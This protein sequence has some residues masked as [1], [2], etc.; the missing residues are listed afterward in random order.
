MARVLITGST[1]GLGR[2]AARTLLDGGH[3]VILHARNPTRAASVDE[4]AGQPDGVVVGDL[5]SMEQTRR[6]AD[7]VNAI[8][9]TDAVIHNAGI[10]LD[11][12]RAETPEGHARTLAVNLLAPYALTAWI[13]RPPRL[14][15][16]SSGMHRSGDSSLNDID[17]TARRW[18][19][20]QA[21]CDS[22]LFLTALAFTVGRHWPDVCSH[23][24]DPGWVPT[25]MGGP[26]APD[27]L[28]LG[29]LTQV[30]LAVSASP[31]V[32]TSG[33]YWYHQTRQSPAPVTLN[34]GFQDALV[35]ELTRLTGVH[36]W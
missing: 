36:L 29:P 8:G 30:W 23:V 19:G 31:E 22:K 15:Y 14:I 2:A 26:G 20:V 24:V 18:N 3:R 27:D 12:Q 25:R 28:A 16:I 34:K 21:Y 7:Q 9:P 13:D 33:G 17:W 10:Y 32:A 5:A 6:V 1:P 35:D 4:L 11:S